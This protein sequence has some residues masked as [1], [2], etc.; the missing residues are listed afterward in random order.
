MMNIAL[1]RIGIR[2]LSFS[3]SILLFLF[4][5]AFNMVEASEPSERKQPIF[6]ANFDNGSL[7]EFKDEML[8]ERHGGTL[9]PNGIV[10]G[11]LSLGKGEYL[12]LNAPRLIRG[13][14][15]TLMFWVRPH[16]D[17][18]GIAS[19]TYLSFPWRDGRNMYFTISRGW[20]EP[21]G[22]R[23]TYLVGNNQDF[24]NLSRHI[25]YEKG[26]WTH[27]ACV[28]K[29]GNPGYIKLYVNGILADTNGRFTGKYSPSGVLYLG[30]D[31]GTILSA[32]RFAD[33]D[34]DELIFYKNTLAD[35]DILAIYNRQTPVSNYP[36]RDAAG[37]LIETRAIFDEGLGWLTE[38]G[39]QTTINRI[40]RAGFN[41]YIPCVWHGGGR[42]YPAEGALSQGGISSQPDP[43]ERLISIAH[44]NGIQVHPWFTVTLREEPSLQDFYDSGTPPRAYDIH[45]PAFRRFITDLIVDVARRYAIDGV[46]LDYIR[47]MGICKCAYCLQEYRRINNRDLLYDSTHPNADGT[48]EQHLQ[49]WQD[50]AVE[51]IVREVSERARK[52][53][54]GCIIS[55]DG[56]PWAKP[57]PEGRQ[58][59]NWANADIVDLVFDMNY[60]QPPDMERY[61]LLLA[62]F[63]DPKKLIMLISNS[64]PKGVSVV[65]KSSE[66]L[67][68]TVDYV[69]RRW[70]TGIGI[71]I[72]SM[73]NDDQVAKLAGG[74]FREI[75]KPR[76]P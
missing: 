1:P 27:L 30:S 40:K 47:S 45:R 24:S 71:Y 16:W 33:A 68:S 73:L 56:Q 17:D 72:Y 2:A 36:I 4:L 43:L 21:A 67:H 63:L 20:W 41:A 39:A 44:K 38:A 64:D 74:A 50:T 65:P 22:A 51:E 12:V 46:N 23:L 42:R 5:S 25:R 53:R 29:S 70:G 6:T 10:G 9:I 3:L 8:L 15:G 58:E 54:P 60:T 32:G 48:I 49:D 19:H 61:N 55:V 13:V 34:F 11:A 75:A 7:N 35:A 59:A 37:V 57:S 52:I 62:K 76:L 31:K 14:E 66:Q 18:A 28:W 26:V 69:R